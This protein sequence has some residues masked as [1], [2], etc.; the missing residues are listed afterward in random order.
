MENNR[1]VI[2][3]NNPPSPLDELV[4]TVDLVFEQG[5]QWLDGEP[6]TTEGMAEGVATL[7]G[8][9]RKATKQVETAHKT[10][11]E[12]FLE[13]GRAVDAKKN[14]L[15]A[16]LTLVEKACKAALLP[17]QQAKAAAQAKAE[18]EARAKAEAAR[19]AAEEARKAANADNLAEREAAT[20]AA[21]EAEKLEAAANKA[22]KASTTT[23]GNT[24]RAVGMVTVYSAEI[25]D[26]QKAAAHYWRNGNLD[27][28]REAVFAQANKD[29]KAGKRNI[30]GITLITKQEVR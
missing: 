4:P 25:E 26:L 24:G 3:G 13:G 20:K 2:G 14:A 16:S 12:P 21:E 27:I 5:K 11:K 1:A 7:L 17:F 23:K 9:V 15:I 19:M 29:V 18:A 8:E 30:P 10:E 28:F 6:V 22:A